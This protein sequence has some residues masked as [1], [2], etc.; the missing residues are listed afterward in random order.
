MKN[1]VKKVGQ[2]EGG[3]LSHKF[4]RDC[5][6]YESEIDMELMEELG[7]PKPCLNLQKY[8]ESPWVVYK[9]I[10]LKDT[11]VAPPLSSYKDDLI[12]SIQRSIHEYFPQIIAK[13]DENAEEDVDPNGN[14][15]PKSDADPKPMSLE[16]FDH[17][18][19][20]EKEFNEEEFTKAVK[21]LTSMK[22]VSKMQLTRPFK[23][24]REKILADKKLYCE[25]SGV[26]PV[27]FWT[28]VL[29]EMQDINDQLK[30]VILRG[31]MH[32][33]NLNFLLKLFLTHKAW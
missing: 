11:K 33:S 32:I 6:C 28:R 2:E 16:V 31:D 30:D 18:F 24:L 3:D 13:G 25:S 27:A 12:T 20:S 8:E 14:P 26:K 17:R 9:S 4:F 29:N 7:Q 22:Y 5:N 19:W 15:Y 23:N 10:H 21:F 1:G